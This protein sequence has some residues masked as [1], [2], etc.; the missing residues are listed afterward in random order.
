MILASSAPGIFG[1][2]CLWQS[3]RVERGAR[4]RLTSQSALQVHPA[5]DGSAARLTS[6]YQVDEEALLRCHWDPVIPFAGARLQQHVDIQLA[7]RGYLEWSDGYMSGRQGRGERWMFAGLAHELRVCRAASLEYLERYRLL[8][9]NRAVSRKWTAGTSAY[10][11]TTLA[12]GPQVGAEIA[13]RLQ[14]ELTGVDGLHAAADALGP[15]LLLVR[16]MAEG[17]VPFHAA[18]ARCLALLKE[19]TEETEATD[20]QRRN[21]ATENQ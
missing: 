16:L 9:E 4:V 11:G 3:V 12:S 7:E 21:G 18:R 13:R 2:D 14:D 6:T 15:A 19:K 17:G 1:G 5:G 8:P 20:S 10:F